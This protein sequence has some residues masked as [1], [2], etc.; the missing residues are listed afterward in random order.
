MSYNAGQE[1]EK[2]ESWGLPKSVLVTYKCGE[3]E[4]LDVDWAKVEGFNEDATEEQVLTAI[5]KVDY[6]SYVDD[7]GAPATVSVKVKVAAPEKV[8]AP[9]ASPA[10]GTYKEA[11]LVELGC[12]TEGVAIRYT[13]DGSEPNEN[14]QVY[15]GE[16]IKV[17]ANTT[18]KAKA[19]AKGMLDSDLAEFTYVIDSASPDPT[20][21]PDDADED[22]ATDEDAN[23]E[24]DNSGSD[25]SGAAGTSS[26]KDEGANESANTG[27][28]TPITVVL[29]V[30]AL[31]GVAALVA[32]RRSSKLF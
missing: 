18:I 12:A 24:A 7:D 16:P 22:G 17:A 2:A 28:V 9:E 10:P 26:A 13:T 3:T 14:S 1:A 27:D 15:K 25:A 11:Q 20:P 32:R 21:A 23:D 5:G 19:F 30:A 4:L 8:Q 29:S 31:A 6:P